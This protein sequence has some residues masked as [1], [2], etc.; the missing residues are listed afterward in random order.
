MCWYVHILF[1]A[2]LATMYVCMLIH[3]VSYRV[4]VV[5][6]SRTNTSGMYKHIYATLTVVVKDG[7]THARK[8]H[9]ALRMVLAWHGLAWHILGTAF[10]VCDLRDGSTNIVVAG[11]FG[12]QHEGLLMNA[13]LNCE[14]HGIG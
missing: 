7:R 3:I 8:K 6:E 2:A 1:L 5:S 4:R 12:F 9:S 13:E 10:T 11:S 14:Y